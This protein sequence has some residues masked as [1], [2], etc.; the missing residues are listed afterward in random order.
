MHLKTKP[1]RIKPVEL[2]EN[3]D[4]SHAKVP[5]RTKTKRDIFSSFDA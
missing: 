3:F 5:T 1:N 2:D 4:S